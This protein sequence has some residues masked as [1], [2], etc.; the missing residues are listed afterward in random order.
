MNSELKPFDKVLVRNLDDGP[1]MI[2]I[3]AYTE[4]CEGEIQHNVLGANY[5]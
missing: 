2:G 4:E 1:W 3:F 5:L